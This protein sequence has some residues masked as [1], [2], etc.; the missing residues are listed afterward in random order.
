MSGDKRK[1]IQQCPK[2]GFKLLCRRSDS[3]IC[4]SQACDWSCKSKRFTD[5]K[6]PTVTELRKDWE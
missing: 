4:L 2:C 6:M 1:E 3:V 5:E